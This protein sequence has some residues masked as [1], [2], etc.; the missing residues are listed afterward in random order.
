MID[1]IVY[2]FTVISLLVSGLNHSM[3]QIDGNG[4]GNPIK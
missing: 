1:I 3:H 4:S 2:M